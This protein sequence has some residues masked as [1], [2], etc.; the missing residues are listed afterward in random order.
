MIIYEKIK[1]YKIEVIDDIQLFTL[2]DKLIQFS[3]YIKP[4]VGLFE[5]KQLNIKIENYKFYDEREWRY[6]PSGFLPCEGFLTKEECEN[7][8][9]RDD[10]NSKLKYLNFDIENIEDIIVPEDEVDIIKKL[11]SKIKRFKNFDLNKIDSLNNRI[12]NSSISI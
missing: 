4:Y 7:D 2:F 12:R 1:Q 9:S 3:M 11:V 5:R 10:Y 6:K 8:N